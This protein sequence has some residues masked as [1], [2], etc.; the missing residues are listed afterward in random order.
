[1]NAAGG[2]ATAVVDAGTGTIA[3]GAPVGLPRYVEVE[4]SRRCNRSCAWC[5]TG[6]T[7]C[8]GVRS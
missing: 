1:M 8:G 7:R 5:P 4:T 6:S 2:Q 3:T